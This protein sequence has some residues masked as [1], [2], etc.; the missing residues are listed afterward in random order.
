[1]SEE[2]VEQAMMAV[3]MTCAAG[4]MQWTTTTMEKKTAVEI[5]AT[6]KLGADEVSVPS[7]RKEHRANPG[8]LLQEALNLRVASSRLCQGGKQVFLGLRLLLP[9]P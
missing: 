7:R 8:L 2:G 5:G 1:M 4:V 9:P 3:T 6:N